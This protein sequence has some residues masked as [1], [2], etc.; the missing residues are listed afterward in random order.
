MGG[1]LELP[2]D[3]EGFHAPLGVFPGRA[4][5]VGSFSGERK[6]EAYEEDSLC[7]VCSV[8]DERVGVWASGHGGDCGGGDGRAGGRWCRRRVWR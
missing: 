1:F 6:E 8:S 3:A 7:W 2:E 5:V 4:S